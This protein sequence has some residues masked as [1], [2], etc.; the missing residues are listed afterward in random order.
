[1]SDVYDL[2]EYTITPAGVSRLYYHSKDV[3][4]SLSLDLSEDGEYYVTVSYKGR[5]MSNYFHTPAL[6]LQWALRWVW[7]QRSKEFEN[8]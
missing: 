4:I 3:E 5:V 7:L 2:S 1:M 6:G 8:A